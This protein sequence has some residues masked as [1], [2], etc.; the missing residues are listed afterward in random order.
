KTIIDNLKIDLKSKRLHISDV[1]DK[2][3]NQYIDLVQK[4]GGVWGIALIGFTY[5]LEKAGIRFLRMAGTSAGAINTVL[6][7][8][9]GTKDQEK[10][11]SLLKFLA[12][13][14]LFD[15]VDGH[16][17]VR[18]GVKYLTRWKKPGSVIKNT[19]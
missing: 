12:Q 11:E 5:V 9:I 6:I 17:L 13:K 18:Q 3:G 16:W 2:H 19:L 10:S 8:A 7:T 14:N 1:E 15:F 4:G